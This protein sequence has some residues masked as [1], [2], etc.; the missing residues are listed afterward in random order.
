MDRN[1]YYVYLHR[2]AS[3]GLPFYVGKGRAYRSNDKINRN[4]WWK[5]VVEKHGYLIEFLHWDLNEDDSKLLEVMEINNKRQ[6][7]YP[8]VNLNNGGEGN[9]GWVPSEET[10]KKISLANT[11]KKVGQETR[12]KQSKA[13][14]GRRHSEEFKKNLT[15][16]NLARTD[17]QN[18]ENGRKR[19]CKQVHGFFNLNN[20]SFLTCT[21]SEL[22]EKFNLNASKVCDIIKG[23]RAHHMGFVHSNSCGCT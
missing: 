20:G 15:A 1:K 8:M 14:T 17:E 2:R 11:G 22:R 18:A 12:E 16:S 5:R 6:L 3:D 23:R 7:G 4:P 9:H 21:Q 13:A 10:K 19:R